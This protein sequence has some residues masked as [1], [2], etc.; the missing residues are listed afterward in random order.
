MTK[1]KSYSIIPDPHW[2]KK[3]EMTL[4]FK[5]LCLLWETEGIMILKN[6]KTR[7]MFLKDIEKLKVTDEYMP[8]YNAF[9]KSVGAFKHTW[10][11]RFF[12]YLW[13]RIKK[14]FHRKTKYLR[15]TERND[16]KC[17]FAGK[18]PGHKKR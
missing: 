15:I 9:K 4:E 1:S 16:R 14:I 7:T 17:N 11:N 10:L 12:Q 18:S 5:K 2:E 8:Q 13:W 6:K 3:I